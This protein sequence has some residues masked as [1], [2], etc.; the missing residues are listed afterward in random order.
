[1]GK[2]MESYQKNL[3]PIHLAKLFNFGEKDIKNGK[4]IANESAKK[5]LE[6]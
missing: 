6:T 2:I 5:I 3:S 4:V 1:M